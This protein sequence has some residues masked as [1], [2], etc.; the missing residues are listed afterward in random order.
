MNIIKKIFDLLS[1][2]ERKHFFLLLLLILLMAIID[3]LGVASILPFVAVLAEP[4]LIETNFFYKYLFKF[5]S[6]FGTSNN[7]EFLFALGTTVFILL[8]VSLTLRAFTTYM[9]ARFTLMREFSIGQKLIEE[10]LNQPYSWFLDRHSADFSKI[11][12]SEVGAVVSGSIKPLLDLIA[13]ITISIALLILIILVDPLLALNTTLIFI[14]IYGSAFFLMKNIIHKIGIGRLN[15]NKERFK[16]VNDAFSALK[17]IKLGG[18]ENIFANR[19]AKPAEIYANNQSLSQAISLLPRYIVEAAAFG[20]V[21]LFILILIKKGENF[22]HIIPII[23]FYVFAGYRLIPALQQI[24]SSIIAIRFSNPALDSLHKDVVHLDNFKKKHIYKNDSKKIKIKKK[25]SLNKISY[26]YPGSQKLILKNINIEI[27]AFSKVGI[28]GETGSG[29]TTLIDIILG[30]L[31]N[32]EGNIN[33]DDLKINSINKRSWQKNIGYVPQQIY[34]SDS[35]I[36]ENIA[37]GYNLKDINLNALDRAAKISNLYDFVKNEL[38]EGYNTMVG[39]R[40]IRLS[41]GQIQRIGIAR[42]IYHDP[43]VLIFDEATSSLDNIT[44]KIVM[45][46][47]D[48]LDKKTTII[49]IAHRLTTLKNCDQIII[50]NKGEVMAKG[51]YSELIKNNHLFQKMSFKDNK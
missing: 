28:V 5:Y 47:I 14:F 48:N 35:T 51:K 36:S 41:G 34:L 40:G 25:I 37:F 24:Y 39:E 10:Y 26:S 22:N 20:G 44:E 4:G 8:I 33:I 19:F 31:D 27:T 21:I 17:L 18:Q 46:S 3:V 12:L 30:L 45:E 32:Y 6:S 49:Q 15:A 50:I 43:E 2:K 23:S 9:L 42:A 11:I 16:I 29:K 38:P 1:Y 13:Q 7:N